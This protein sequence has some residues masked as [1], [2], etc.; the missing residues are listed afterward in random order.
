MLKA[1]MDLP[2]VSRIPAELVLDPNIDAFILDDDNSMIRNL[3]ATSPGQ[4][5]RLLKSIVSEEMSVMDDVV[6]DK[7]TENPNPDPLQMTE[8]RT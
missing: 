2:S 5:H 1:G 7:P 3:S 8:N 6:V 4:G